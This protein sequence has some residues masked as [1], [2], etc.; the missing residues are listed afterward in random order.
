MTETDS[1]R[2]KLPALGVKSHDTSGRY[3]SY[4]I[5]GNGK[6]RLIIGGVLSVVQSL[7]SLAP[8]FGFIT[9]VIVAIYYCAYYFDI[10]Q[11]TATGEDQ[12]PE[13]FFLQFN[14]RYRVACGPDPDRFSIGSDELFFLN[15]FVPAPVV[16]LGIKNR[17]VPEGLFC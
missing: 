7:A 4:A 9:L 13:F 15:E 16:L 17:R 11:S 8:R 1:N 6:Y 3:L 10:V 14:H 5:R 12:A 2:Y